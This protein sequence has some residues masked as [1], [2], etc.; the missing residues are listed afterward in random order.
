MTC[1]NF[2]HCKSRS[3]VDFSE[4]K[5]A[6]LAHFLCCSPDQLRQ[7]LRRM[8]QANRWHAYFDFNEAV[9]IDSVSFAELCTPD[10][11]LLLLLQEG[12]DTWL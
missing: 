7:H 1:V 8:K 2:N 5:N 10:K 9:N 12:Q 3:T 11:T 4:L 6:G